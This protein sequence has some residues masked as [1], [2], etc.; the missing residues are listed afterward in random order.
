MRDIR[1]LTTDSTK[2]TAVGGSGLRRA[3]VQA[4]G[5]AMALPRLNA[6]YRSLPLV[7]EPERF[8]DATLAA[9][10]VTMDLGGSGLDFI[11]RTGPCVVVANHP[12]GALDGLLLAQL[13]LRRRRD[14]RILGNRLLEAVPELAAL[15]IGV[16]VL[17][18]RAGIQTN[19]AGIRRALRWLD[20]GGMLAMFPAGEVSHLRLS[21]RGIVDP[22]WT[23]AAA[24]IIRLSRAPVLPV[25]F[26]GRNSWGFQFAGLLHPRLRTALLPR[27]LLNK[28][29]RRVRIRTGRPLSADHIARIQQ[30]DLLA[31]HLRLQT[32]ALAVDACRTTPPKN[33][34]RAQAPL[35]TAMDP[36]LLAAQIRSLPVT[37]RLLGNSEMSVFVVRADQ[38][39]AILAELGRLREMT[40]RAVGEG[41]GRCADL[42]DYD[43]RYEHLL[44]WHDARCEIIGAYRI[45]RSDEILAAHGLAGLYTPTLFRFDRRFFGKLPPALELGR[46]FVRAEYQRSFAPLFL[47]WKGVAAY[48]A[49]HP[50]YSVLFGAV[51]ISDD[52]HPLSKEFL[53]EFLER[54]HLAPELARWVRAR[55]PLP[56]RLSLRTLIHPWAGPDGIDSL[57][58]LVGRF[59]PDGKGVPVLLRQYLKLGGRVAGFNVDRSFGDSIDCLLVVDLHRTDPRVLAKYMGRA[60]SQAY[61][62]GAS[63]RSATVEEAHHDIREVAEQSV[64]PFGIEQGA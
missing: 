37:A 34:D 51:S 42:D 17:R 9:L 2:R 15:L 40:F 21:A 38:A 63:V 59:E 52:Y 61:V 25:H 49:R 58:Q 22:N 16:E 39:P 14:V 44:I 33:K 55:H 6:L 27:E 57:D 10:D 8:L 30:D 56:R 60:Q 5:N 19:I 23:E 24:R 3:F 43:E 11:P 48:V 1:L 62:S 32:Y 31:S 53:R 29:R 36:V 47:L 20:G 4:A 64:D 13:L 7:D 26:E 50:R 12:Y 18:G 41:T 35:A 46:S 45:G 28:R 54:R